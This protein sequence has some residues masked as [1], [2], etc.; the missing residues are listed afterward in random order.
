MTAGAMRTQ[1]AIVGGGIGGVAAALS[2]LRAEFDV[3]VY[4]QVR[5]FREVGAGININPEAPYPA[6]Q[7]QP[8]AWMDNGGPLCIALGGL[9]HHYVRV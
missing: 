9:H 1:V 6:L 8:R 5:A 7:L 3:H 2:L 4:E